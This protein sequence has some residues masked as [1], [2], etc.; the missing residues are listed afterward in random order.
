MIVLASLLSTL[1]TRCGE[2]HEDGLESRSC[3]GTLTDLTH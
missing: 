3:A 2:L 1:I